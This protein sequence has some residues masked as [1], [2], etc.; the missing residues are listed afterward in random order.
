MKNK[1]YYIIALLLLFNY[2][3][4]AQMTISFSSQINYVCDGNPCEYTGPSILINEVMLT[5]SIND[6]SIYGTG[7]GFTQGDNEGEWI[8]LYNPD[9]C[10]PVDISCYYLGNNAPDDGLDFGG[11]YR[12]P[13]NTVVPPGGFVVIRGIYAPAVPS[14]LLVQNGGTTI[15]IIADNAANNICLDGGYRLWFPNIGGWFAFYDAAGIPQD[16]ISWGDLSNSCASCNPCISV[17]T[18]CPNATN[19]SNYNAIPSA[20]KTYVTSANPSSF[21]GESWRR[22]PDGGSWNSSP[23]TPTIGTC[24]SICNPVPVIT[25]NGQATAIV[26]G[27]VSP[28]TY[29]WNDTQASTTATVGG[30]CG[31]TYYVTVTDVNSNSIIDSVTI[32]NFQPTVLIDSIPPQCDNASAIDLTAFAIP[33]GGI[34]SGNGVT[35]TIFDPIAAG[36]GT[37][38]ITYIFSDT[39]ACA[40]TAYQNIIVNPTPSISVNS[41]TICEGQSVIIEAI[42]DL[43]G[44]TYLW[45]PTGQTTQSI[46]VVPTM[47]MTYS[48]AYALNGCTT[49]EQSSVIVNINPVV[50]ISGNTLVLPGQS[51]TLTASGGDTYLWSNGETTV[52]INVT[53]TQTTNF[54]VIAGNIQGCYDTACLTVDI[55]CPSTLYVPN[56]F[57]PNGDQWNEKFETPGTYIDDFHIMIYNRWGEQVFESDNIQKMWDG[58]YNGRAVPDGVYFYLIEAK[59]CDKK[60]YNLKGTVTVLK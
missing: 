49:S 32:Q 12:I 8:E 26:S 60:Q 17:Y 19:L 38:I 22:I 5:P 28:Y 18:G 46:A 4:K 30:L 31:G 21:P 29:A 53:P 40:D 56:C 51:T 41:D 14:N 24:N 50:T 2:F 48:V 42:P 54:C 47:T 57:T 1:K 45:T 55:D 44:G 36:T 43:P 23:S 35:D 27:G 6:G 13:D 59:G 9:L 37:H 33:S 20:N 7:P 58:K 39:N 3:T 52:S 10:K 16:A 34:Y 11:G 25:C 15:E